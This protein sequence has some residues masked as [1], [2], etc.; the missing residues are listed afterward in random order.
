MLVSHICPVDDARFW[1]QKNM[2]LALLLSSAP[3]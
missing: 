2:N 1:H 3:A